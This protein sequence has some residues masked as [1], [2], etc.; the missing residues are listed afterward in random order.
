M[1]DEIGKKTYHLCVARSRSN[2]G[3]LLLLVIATCFA[4]I[5]YCF[6]LF[7]LVEIMTLVFA[8]V[9]FWQAL[10]TY[11]FRTVFMDDRIE[12]TTRLGFWHG[13]DYSKI[14]VAEDRGESISITGEDVMGKTITIQLLKRD[15]NYDEVLAFLREKTSSSSGELRT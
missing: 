15:G 11:V 5:I 4:F 14:M 3:Y 8:G 6:G 1:T 7:L 12:H 2:Q 10:R 13:L 9:T